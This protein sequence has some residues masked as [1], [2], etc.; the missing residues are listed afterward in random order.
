MENLDHD[1]RGFLFSRFDNHP[2]RLDMGSSCPTGLD[3]RCI[4]YHLD[5]VNPLTTEDDSGIVKG[6]PVQAIIVTGI[7]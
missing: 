4:G 6:L 3:T 1:R 7:C 2:Q 5:S